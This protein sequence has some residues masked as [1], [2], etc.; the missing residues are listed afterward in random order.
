MHVEDEFEEGFDESVMF[1]G[2]GQP[3]TISEELDYYDDVLVGRED[4]LESQFVKVNCKES[5]R[6]K[7]E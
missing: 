6:A 4:T 2:P 5:K 7:D 1:G 3:M